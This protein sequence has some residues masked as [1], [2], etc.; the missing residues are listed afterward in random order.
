MDFPFWGAFRWSVQAPFLTAREPWV[1]KLR[2]RIA[3][4]IGRG[5]LPFIAAVGTLALIIVLLM[6]L[7]PATYSDR[8]SVPRSA[9]PDEQ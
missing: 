5:N 2:K 4:S 7:S 1:T 3:R 6:V 9:V 8:G